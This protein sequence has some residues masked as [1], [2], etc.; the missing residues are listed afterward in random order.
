MKHLSTIWRSAGDDTKGSATM[1]FITIHLT[2]G[3]VVYHVLLDAIGHKASSFV[4]VL[5]FGV[6]PVVIAIIYALWTRGK[7]SLVR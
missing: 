2:M 3:Y 7:K 1:L 4:T 6:M 5:L